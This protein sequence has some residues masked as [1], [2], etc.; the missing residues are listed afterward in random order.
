MKN[1]ELFDI[2]VLHFADKLYKNFPVCV[3]VDMYEEIKKEPFASVRMDEFKKALIL[4]ETVF[5]LEENGFL[6][7]EH[8]TNR[9]NPSNLEPIPSQFFDCMR[10]TAKGLSILKAPPK[11]I[12]KKESM[13]EKIANDLQVAVTQKTLSKISDIA[14]DFITKLAL[15]M[16]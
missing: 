3:N 15:N 7:F 5:W 1:I 8:N 11:A 9:L 6:K 13:G 12:E 10:L 2:A 14:A 16:F 4:S